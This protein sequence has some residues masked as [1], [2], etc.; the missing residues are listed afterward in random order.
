M[1]R[2]PPGSRATAVSI[3]FAKRVLGAGLEIDRLLV[4][5]ERGCLG[6]LAL[7]RSVR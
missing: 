2:E 5:V 1:T 6:Y 3:E 4:G 7:A